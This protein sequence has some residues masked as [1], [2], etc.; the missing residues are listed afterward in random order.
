MKQYLH[1]FVSSINTIILSAILFAT[2]GYVIPHI[3]YEFFDTTNYYEI[4]TPVEVEQKEYQP[5]QF[6]KIYLVRNSL[7]DGQGKSIINL[8]LIK[9]DHSQE[10]IDTSIKEIGFTKGSGLIIVSWQI[11][12]QATPGAYFFR[13]TMSYKVREFEKF[14]AFETIPFDVIASSS[15]EIKK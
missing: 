14:T 3:Y 7:I 8:E 1:H 11:S 13:G 9:D 5:C 15:A 2:F 4:K 6:A 10:R 12:C